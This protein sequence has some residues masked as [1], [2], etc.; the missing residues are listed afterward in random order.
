[1]TGLSRV[2]FFIINRTVTF[3]FYFLE[4]NKHCTAVKHSGTNDTA[5]H[6]T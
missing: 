6:C 5:L 4:I 2:S 3:L 1:M